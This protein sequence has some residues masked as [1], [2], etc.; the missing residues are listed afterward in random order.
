MPGRA[1]PPVPCGEVDLLLP[2]GMMVT[3]SATFSTTLRQLKDRLYQEA[4]QHPLFSMLK[5]QGFYNFLGK[6]RFLA[7]SRHVGLLPQALHG[8][9][10]RRNLLMKKC[11]WKISTYMPQVDLLLWEVRDSQYLG[12]AVLKLVEREGNQEEKQLNSELS[13]LIGRRTCM[14]DFDTMGTEVYMCGLC[15][16]VC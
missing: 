9:E 7:F 4:K 1:L 15:K 5:D 13:N 2:T 12:V 8:M 14:H 6:W 11:V 3:L 16:L 10:R